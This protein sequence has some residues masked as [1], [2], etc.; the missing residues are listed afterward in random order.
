[1]ATN[2]TYAIRTHVDTTKT[3]YTEYTM[4]SLCQYKMNLANQP[5]C[6][7]AISCQTIFSCFS[8]VV[9]ATPGWTDAQAT[10]VCLTRDFF[11]FGLKAAINSILPNVLSRYSVLVYTIK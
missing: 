11:V 6:I 1:M 2:V 4:F 5:M 9:V 7:K 10:C 8:W 3:S